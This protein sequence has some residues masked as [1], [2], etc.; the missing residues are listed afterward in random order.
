MKNHGRDWRRTLLSTD[1]ETA[2]SFSFGGFVAG[3]WGFFIWFWVCLGFFFKTPSSFMI[4]KV[5]FHS[6]TNGHLN[7]R[8]VLSLQMFAPVAKYVWM[9]ET[10]SLSK[11]L[12]IT[13]LGRRQ[14]HSQ[15]CRRD[16]PG[17][18][19]P[20]VQKAPVSWETPSPGDDTG[21]QRSTGRCSAGRITMTLLCQILYFLV[22]LLLFSTKSPLPCWWQ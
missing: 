17:S 20:K 11:Y 9:Q 3:G 6:K 14:C 16:Q 21:I 2:S 8:N 4:K 13:S 12:A 10:H 18:Q 7:I 15:S 19:A 1:W 22:R 5:G